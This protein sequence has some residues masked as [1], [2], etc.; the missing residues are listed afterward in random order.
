MMSSSVKDYA[1]KNVPKNIELG[2]EEY[3]K[4][5]GKVF[6][7]L[8]MDEIEDFQKNELPSIIEN[9][10]SDEEQIEE[11]RSELESNS[12]KED[13]NVFGNMSPEFEDKFKDK[14]EARLESLDFVEKVDDKFVITGDQVGEDQMQQIIQS[15]M[16]ETMDEEFKLEKATK[17]EIEV[18]EKKII[19][20]LS[21]TLNVDKEEMAQI[22]KGGTQVAKEKE[23][24]TVVDNL[25]QN[26][27]GEKEE[28]VVIGDKA[29]GKDDKTKA[30]DKTVVKDSADSKASNLTEIELIKKLKKSEQE[31]K[32]LENNLK[33]LE[34]KLKSQTDSQNKINEIDKKSK[35]EVEK[36][37]QEE[38]K[39]S[40]LP[41]DNGLNQKAEDVVKDLKAGKEANENGQ[42]ALEALLEREKEILA[43]AK[44]F[45]VNLK[46]SQ[47]EMNQK[48]SL[49]KSEIE[50]V[51]RTLKGKD[52]VIEKIKE[53][54]QTLASKKEKEV[55]GLVTQLEELNQRLN[56]DSS[57]KL[58][59]QVKSL[60]SDNEKL[61]K[62]AE[63]FKNR[64]ETLSKSNKAQAGSDNTK[65]LTDDNRALKTAKV[66]LENKMNAAVK[67]VKSLESRYNKSK[68]LETMFRNESTKFKAK[69]AD[70]ELQVKALKDNETRL[71]AIASK[72]QSGASGN[73][74]AKEL[75]SLKTQNTQLQTKLKEMLEKSKGGV[76][77]SGAGAV[78]SPKEKHL[79]KE[80]K[81]LQSQVS[82]SRAELEANKKDMMKMKGSQ[83]KLLN[84]IAK[85][86][87]DLEKATAASKAKGVGK[88]AA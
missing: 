11:F 33:V 62:S 17:A 13:T 30:E 43:K 65:Q 79:E 12:S 81:S 32:K 35:A 55:G 82:K 28:K 40:A 73:N 38:K 34:T 44:D 64:L 10:L 46:K 54:M 31:K 70:L 29:F 48:E 53:S 84:E 52:L 23:L 4:K 47:L 24:Q 1:A 67:E 25:F 51:S 87:K 71:T 69:A 75:D 61:A 66:Q 39:D 76:A 8:S 77:T 36:K 72:A 59:T 18:Q 7:N 56:N 5:M 68:E 49:F 41:A 6:E 9:T 78:Q 60:Q 26:Q 3:A 15:T 21:A 22:V 14:L 74:S 27:P 16:K 42:K 20:G 19:E 85:L 2:M 58:V 80:K 50:L 83:T 63:M 37:I 57:T 88:K 86:K 45:E